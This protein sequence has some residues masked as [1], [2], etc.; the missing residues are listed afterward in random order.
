MIIVTRQE[1]RL[2]SIEK[3]L[4]KAKKKFPK[5][6]LLLT[7]EQLNNCKECFLHY[8]DD[9]LISKEQQYPTLFFSHQVGIPLEAVKLVGRI[10][11][12]VKMNMKIKM[13]NVLI[14][15]ETNL[16]FGIGIGMGYEDENAFN[17]PRRNN[18]KS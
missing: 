11:L 13:K 5:T 4:P 1:K 16:K 2:L 7:V 6:K 10:V 8:F 14:L 12:K 9:I 17:A 3:Q 18:S 15:K